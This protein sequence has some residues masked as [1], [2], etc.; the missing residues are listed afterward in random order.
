MGSN[1]SLLENAPSSRSSSSSSVRSLSSASST[2]SSSSL[3]KTSTSSASSTQSSSSLSKRSTSSASSSKSKKSNYE[4]TSSDSDSDS[5]TKTIRSEDFDPEESAQ[6]QSLKS[7][8]TT[9]SLNF[10]KEDETQ[11]VKLLMRILK[12]VKE[13]S[14]DTEAHACTCDTCKKSDFTEYRYKCLVCIDFDLCGACFEKR[15]LSK[16]HQLNHPMVR[17]DMP[18][19]LFGL[20]FENSE[21]SMDNFRKIFK[22]ELHETVKCDICLTNPMRGLR[23]KCDTCHDYDVCFECYSKK[24]SSKEHKFNNHPLL[25]QG[26]SVSLELDV[27][28]IELIAELGS[29]AFGTV[30]KSKLKNLND[31][32]VACK[33]IT[34]KKDQILI[35]QLLGMDPMTLYNSYVQELNAYKELKGVNILK[36]FGHCTNSIENKLEL[37]IVTEFMSKGS[38]TCLLEK[39]TDLSFRKRFSIAYDIASGM[40]RIHE[41]HFIHRDIRPDNILIAKDYTAKIGDMGIAKFVEPNK[42]TMIGCKA[43]MPPEFYTGKYD[44]KLDVFTFGLTLNILF[45]GTHNEQNPIRI[46]KKSLIFCEFT[47]RCLDHN[48]DKRPT[49]QNI[50]DNFRIIKKVFHACIFQTEHFSD[51][52]G[53]ST[54]NKNEVFKYLYQKLLKEKIISI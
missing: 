19:E 7:P 54:E 26:K 49:S 45:G 28:N 12:L 23:F 40:A 11:L 44:E 47:D 33:V 6:A 8:S 52:I 41:H 34:I 31:K 43:Y 32:I 25:F 36:M 13:N 42:N 5:D 37:M 18:N 10:S 21:I 15:K 48:P 16:N 22:N 51:Y 2:Q 29:G 17:F 4:I 27:E 53:M 35:M 9:S 46:E 24:L 38:L 3:S 50:L 39:E 20:K 30:W 1:G 14:S